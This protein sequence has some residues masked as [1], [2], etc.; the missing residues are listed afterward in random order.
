MQ[1]TLIRTTAIQTSVINH[2]SPSKLISLDAIIFIFSPHLSH[3]TFLRINQQSSKNIFTYSFYNKNSIKKKP[4]WDCQ[5]DQTD[6]TSNSLPLVLNV[7]ETRTRCS[8]YPCTNDQTSF[9]NMKIQRELKQH[10]ITLAVKCLMTKSNLRL[11]TSRHF[12]ISSFAIVSPLL[13][14]SLCIYWR[15]LINI[16][17]KIIKDQVNNEKKKR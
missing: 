16:Q 12:E 14:K 11:K 8:A 15:N 2:T 13:W 9:I 4:C 1:H 10:K 6:F 17:W 7:T 3:F 5:K